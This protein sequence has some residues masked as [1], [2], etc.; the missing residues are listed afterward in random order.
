MAARH[1]VAS[2]AFAS[3]VAACGTTTASPS[4]AAATPTTVAA[5]TTGAS[6]SPA[7][8]GTATGSSGAASGSITIEPCPPTPS[9]IVCLPP[10]PGTSHVT[11]KRGGT[12]GLLIELAN[13]GS[14]PSSPVAVLLHVADAASTLPLGQPACTTCS[15]TATSKMIGLEWPALAAGETRTV[16]VDI[17]VTGSGGTF[18]ADLYA[19]PLADVMTDQIANGTTP[20]QQSWTV[21]LAVSG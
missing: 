8:S 9:T 4:P 15:S 6:G 21:D 13:P 19:R 18:L 16:S 14:T 11:V 10:T 2:L 20:G 7:S 17:P 5:A 3:F 1:L 12:M